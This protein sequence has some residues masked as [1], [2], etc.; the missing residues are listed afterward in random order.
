MHLQVFVI[1]ARKMSTELCN[2]PPRS[3]KEIVRWPGT[4]KETRRGSMVIVT[5]AVNLDIGKFTAGS[6]RKMR[7]KNQP[8]TMA[9]M[10]MPMCMW[11][12][13]SVM[14]LSMYCE[15]LT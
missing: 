15:Q 12:I 9:G 3:R 2:V 11:T 4:A 5:N 6:F 10:S 8:V 13:V 14:K 1:C 7:Q